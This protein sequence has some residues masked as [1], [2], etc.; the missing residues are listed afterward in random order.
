MIK[1]LGLQ[2]YTLRDFFKDEEFTDLTFKKM[3]DLGYTEAHTAGTYVAADKFIELAHKHGINF[4]RN[5][6]RL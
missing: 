6:L 1:K 5:T 2:L 4:H 3:A